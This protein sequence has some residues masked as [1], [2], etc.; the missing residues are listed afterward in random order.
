MH[1]SNF[2][3]P[4][5][6]CKKYTDLMSNIVVLEAPWGVRIIKAKWQSQPRSQG[7][8]I[9]VPGSRFFF[10]EV[11]VDNYNL[12]HLLVDFAS[13][14]VHLRNMAKSACSRTFQKCLFSIC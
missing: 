4:Y 9:S 7:F 8:F 1:S 11:R 6:N 5:H 2:Y 14:L 10:H 13:R 12:G 3:Y